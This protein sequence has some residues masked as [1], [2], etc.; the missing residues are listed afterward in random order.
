VAGDASFANVRSEEAAYRS[1]ARSRTQDLQF[2]IIRGSPV[3]DIEFHTVQLMLL[4][5]AIV[6]AELPLS[7]AY[8]MQSA[9]D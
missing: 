6:T 9:L 8:C 4:I 5:D 2:L 7:I 1:N 3:D